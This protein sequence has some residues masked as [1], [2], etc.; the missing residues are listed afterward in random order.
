MSGALKQYLRELPNPLLTFALHSEWIAAAGYNIV[1]CN[2]IIIS[3]TCSVADEGERAQQLW[4][5]TKK[6]P[7]KIFENLK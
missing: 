6:L 2:Y 3:V 5:V 7:E 1:V 4:V